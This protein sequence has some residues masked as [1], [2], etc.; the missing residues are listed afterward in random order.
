MIE[1]PYATIVSKLKE[2]GGL[3][4]EQIEQR[5]GEKLKQL[6]G[7]ISK[8]G[9]AHIIANEVGVKLVEATS[10]KV[11]I[12]DALPGMKSVEL[13][14]KVTRV[15]ELREFERDGRQGK[16]ANFIMGDESGTI[17]VVMWGEMAEQL[18]KLQEGTTIK[19]SGGL[20]RD[21]QGRSEIHLNDRSELT[22]NPLDVD[23]GDVV[24]RAPRKPIK[25]LNSS[26]ENVELL[27]TIVQLF[28]PRF[29]DRKPYGQQEAEPKR[30]YVLNA[31]LDDGTAT[32]QSVFWESQVQKL[33]KRS[34]E[35]ILA[36][37]G[38][39]AEFEPIK[40]D[41]LGQIIKLVGRVQRNERFERDEFVANLVFADV[42]PKQELAAMGKEDQ[43][44]SKQKDDQQSVEGSSTPSSAPAPEPAQQDAA[45]V[46]E[47]PADTK[48]RHPDTASVAD[49]ESAEEDFTALEEEPIS[50]DDLEEL[51]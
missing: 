15:F 25:E 33:L 2:Q 1:V 26:D 23:V 24:R 28:T 29:F 18:R 48:T 38:S 42:D 30:S 32:I 12:R 46:K 27:A 37:D 31:V 3:S 19:L 20:V 16:V 44:P 36:F 4:E 6:G 39:P 13:V 34:H 49:D 21:N 50:L 8:E 11:R 35:E 5:V 40:N 7:L 14:G 22:I 51:D 9:A 45:T 43:A 41:L 10:G 17:R 47:A